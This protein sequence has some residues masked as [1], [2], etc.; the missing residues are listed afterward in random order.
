M[1]DAFG[2][3]RLMFGSDWPV[4]RLAAYYR[5]VLDTAR[6]LTSGLGPAEHREVFAG[7]AVRVYGLRI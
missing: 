5:E 3:D 1:L 4:C 6:S 7:T 2:P